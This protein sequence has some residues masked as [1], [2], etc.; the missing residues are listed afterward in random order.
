MSATDEWKLVTWPNGETLEMHF[1]DGKYV[2]EWRE[3]NE[4]NSF[5]AFKTDWI[6]Q[7]KKARVTL[8]MLRDSING[9]S[10]SQVAMWDKLQAAIEVVDTQITVEEALLT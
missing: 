7:L 4:V 5:R 10:P 6:K 2:G 9:D 1:I 8:S 3:P